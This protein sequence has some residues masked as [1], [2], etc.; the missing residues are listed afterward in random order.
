MADVVLFPPTSSELLRNKMYQKN[1]YL[2]KLRRLEYFAHK[3]RKILKIIACIQDVIIRFAPIFRFK[4]NE[5]KFKGI[6]VLFRKVVTEFKKHT[7][8]MTKRGMTYFLNLFALESADQ[9]IQKDIFDNFSVIK[10]NADRMQTQLH[11]IVNAIRSTHPRFAFLSDDFII[12]L[13]QTVFLPEV[14][15]REPHRPTNYLWGCGRNSSVASRCC[16]RE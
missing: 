8:D 15:S 9:S 7:D 5:Q 3:T 11:H 4:E 16:S 14:S 6:E 2:D 13:S 12:E 1:E 10:A